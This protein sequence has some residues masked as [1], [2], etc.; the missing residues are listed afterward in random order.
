[1]SACAWCGEAL[2]D[3]ACRWACDDDCVCGSPV[4]D[5]HADGP[6]PV[7]EA[8]DRAVLRLIADT[9]ASMPPPAPKLP[10]AEA[11]A[12]L[13]LRLDA[14]CAVEG[15]GPIG[16]PYIEEA[17][18]LIEPDRA[19]MEWASAVCPDLAARLEDI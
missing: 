2:V 18:A 13:L 12:S 14:A 1:M 3:G 17:L 5:C 6:C 4:G 9:A 19:V 7:A 8:D 11:I 16:V 10:P 15:I